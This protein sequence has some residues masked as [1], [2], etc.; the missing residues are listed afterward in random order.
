[1]EQL[2]L[3]FGH[4]TDYSRQN[5]IPLQSNT[6]ALLVINATPAEGLVVYGKT[7]VG[8]THLLHI[9]AEEM[10]AQLYSAK[11][12]PDAFNGTAFAIDD[13]DLADKESQTKLFH[14]FNNV[15]EEGGALAFSS[16]TPV[17]QLESYLPDLQSRLLTF[18]QV[19]VKEPEMEEM[20][21]LLAKESYDRQ[22]AISPQVVD[23]IITH[24]PRQPA[25]VMGLLDQL[26]K[27]SM[28]EKRKI[29]IPLVKE[30][31]SV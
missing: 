19:E 27:L 18:Q 31:L 24:S 21:L 4:K 8:K 20:R 2:T 28:S 3:G 13:I 22:I 26:D 30:T 25:F 5:F 17:A 16:T 6:D 14:L 23:Y 1:M 11:D 10:G 29:T 12:L 15:K 7:A 9:W